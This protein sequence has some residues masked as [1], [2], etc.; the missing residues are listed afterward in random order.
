MQFFARLFRRALIALFHAAA[1]PL[2][3]G[4]QLGLTPVETPPELTGLLGDP[5]AV[6]IAADDPFR[7]TEPGTVTDPL[8]ELTGCWAA[9]DTWTE[10]IGD[11][12][13]GSAAEAKVEGWQLYRFGPDAD[14]LWLSFAEL[15]GYGAVEIRME[16]SYEIQ[17]DNRLVLQFP[18]WVE[19]LPGRQLA[20]PEDA[21]QLIENDASLSDAERADALAE[22][23][24]PTVFEYLVTLDGNR[25]LLVG[26]W[27]NEEGEESL[28]DEPVALVRVAC[29]GE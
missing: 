10:S 17:G 27:T 23:E 13:A 21:R 9:Y 5:A 24:E 18:S 7:N 22:L 12:A 26:V 1:I 20:W 6:T 8:S 3:G 14:A 15:N 25:L 4:C 19:R 11:A 16:G 2:L 29:I 28:D